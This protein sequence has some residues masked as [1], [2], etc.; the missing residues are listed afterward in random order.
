MRNFLEAPRGSL[1]WIGICMQ[2]G[3]TA[4]GHAKHWHFFE[5]GARRS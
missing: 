2:N 5:V 4:V 3:K 1:P